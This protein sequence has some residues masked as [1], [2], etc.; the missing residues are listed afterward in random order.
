LVTFK[1]ASVIL[2]IAVEADSE[3]SPIA[4][5]LVG[6]NVP[7]FKLDHGEPMEPAMYHLPRWL[8]ERPPV[9]GHSDI[10]SVWGCGEWGRGGGGGLV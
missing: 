5:T 6:E 9:S 3:N 4:A 2:V 8:W 7:G 1:L 10:A